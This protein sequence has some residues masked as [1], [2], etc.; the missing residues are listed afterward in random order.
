MR[1]SS[2]LF[3]VDEGANLCYACAEQRAKGQPRKG[4]QIVKAS[5]LANGKP[6]GSGRPADECPFRRPFPQGFDQCPTFRPQ[7]FTPLDMSG[8][9]LAPMLT[10]GQLV[11]RSLAN[12]KVGW[13]AACR[14]GDETAR[15][16]LAEVRFS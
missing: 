6:N 1:N 4:Q 12:G 8:R 13:Y 14:I 5:Q 2:A 16:K 11:T 9:P 15:R 7:P 10:C 3:C